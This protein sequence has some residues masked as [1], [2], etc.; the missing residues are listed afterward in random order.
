MPN[1]IWKAL[2][3]SKFGI[4]IP[5][6]TEPEFIF[7]TVGVVSRIFE[8]ILGSSILGIQGRLYLHNFFF[9]YIELTVA[10]IITA[11]QI[12]IDPTTLPTIMYTF[13]LSE[14]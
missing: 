13:V 4:S 11:R 2:G 14:S 9:K 3:S 7:S 6:S 5:I 10:T 12:H 1:A 8:E